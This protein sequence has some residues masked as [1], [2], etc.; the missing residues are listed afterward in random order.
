MNAFPM[1]GR[2]TCALLIIGLIF[3]G[4]AA[5][6]SAYRFEMIVFERPGGEPAEQTAMQ[7]VVAPRR[8]RVR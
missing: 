5:A 4:S 2:H 3:T 8:V 7:H 1:T 6:G